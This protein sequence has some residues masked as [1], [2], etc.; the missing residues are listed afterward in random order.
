MPSISASKFKKNVHVCACKY[1][2]GI[3][4]FLKLSGTLHTHT[5]TW[6]YFSYFQRYQ[7]VALKISPAKVNFGTDR[8][9]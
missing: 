7:L 4:E 9:P 6:T 3:R 8:F 1:P 5:R 2:P